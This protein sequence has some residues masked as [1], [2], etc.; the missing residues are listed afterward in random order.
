MLRKGFLDSKYG[1]VLCCCRN[2][3]LVDDVGILI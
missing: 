3:L 1:S 2:C